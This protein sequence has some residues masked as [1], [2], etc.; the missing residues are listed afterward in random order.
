[1]SNGMYLEWERSRFYI[2]L[3]DEKESS[4]ALSIE[5]FF[6]HEVIHDQVLHVSYSV[7]T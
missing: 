1:M 5:G 4:H 6:E 3:M 2:Y 7:T